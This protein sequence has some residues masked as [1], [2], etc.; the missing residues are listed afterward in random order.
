[1]ILFVCA[2]H[3]PADPELIAAWYQ[4]DRTFP[5]FRQLW[6]ESWIEGPSGLTPEL[7][8]TAH[9]IL[10]NGD[11]GPM[12]LLDVSVSGL[13]LRRAIAY[14]DQKLKRGLHPASF[15]FADL[16][17]DALDAL[18]AAGRPVWWRMDPVSVEPGGVAE[19]MV[20]LRSH[21]RS[22]PLSVDVQTSSGVLHVPVASSPPP[23]HIASIGIA[24]STDTAWVYVRSE[25]AEV[26]RL[27]SVH[28]DGRDVTSRSSVFHDPALPV[29][30]V[31]VQLEEPLARGTFHCF[32]VTT[33][34]RSTAAAGL[35]VFPTE[36][37]YGVWG[38]Q[39]GKASEAERA[40]AYLHEIAA[41]NIN[42]QMP[43]V[44]SAAVREFLKTDQ[45]QEQMQSLGIRRMISDPGKG[46]TRDPYAYFLVDEP[47]CGDWR[48]RGLP[49]DELVG[50]LAQSLVDR[51]AT[52]RDSDPVTPH[53]INVDLTFKPENWYTYGQLPDILAADPYYQ[54]RL[55]DA[56]W[57]HPGR[58]RLFTR[59]TWVEAIARICH[60]AC[61][62]RPLHI[63][64]YAVSHR[65]RT[66]GRSPWPNTCPGCAPWAW[67][68]S[69]SPRSRLGSA[70]GG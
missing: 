53:V 63:I 50:S 52:F 14:S 3:A 37:A 11:Q 4:P 38:S 49:A 55:R 13:S 42:V 28:V 61:M 43:M 64:L 22:T 6:Y 54:P 69:R 36:L 57:E 12:R 9:V 44:G 51:S 5:E 32:T 27:V 2:C 25:E 33:D 19:A 60:R 41:H 58:L 47:D 68:A 56:Y 70:A 21:P 65:R 23:A 40:R 48:V 66:P 39:P 67:A 62:P 24:R 45:G 8:G 26:G 35:R 15:R 29:A 30:L 1:M 20:R 17:D 16:S 46:N 18:I 34:D 10:R 7:G 59:A 31:V